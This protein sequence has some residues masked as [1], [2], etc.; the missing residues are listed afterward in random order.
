MLVPANPYVKE[1][2][3][4]RNS[5]FR[6]AGIVCGFRIPQGAGTIY[7]NR[8]RKAGIISRSQILP[9]SG[10]DRQTIVFENHSHVIRGHAAV[11]PMIF[12]KIHLN[13]QKLLRFFQIHKSRRVFK[14]FFNTLSFIIKSSKAKTISKA[15]RGDKDEKEK[16]FE[17]Y[18]YC[19]SHLK[20][21]GHRIPDDRTR[22][23]HER[24]HWCCERVRQQRIFFCGH[25]K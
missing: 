20:C 18:G 11:L 8:L 23:G 4:Y 19:S 5:L 15:I 12:L 1:N 10:N 13:M 21:C 25:F 22:R 14:R 6:I 3:A 17:A 16:L 9:G 2:H 24:E 7:V